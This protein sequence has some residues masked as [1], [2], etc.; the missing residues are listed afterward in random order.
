[1]IDLLHTLFYFIV[2]ISVL[3]SIHE[4]GHF[5][6]ARLTGVKVLRFSIGF[7]KVL[8]A[9][10]KNAGTTEYV[11]S[12]IPLGGYVKMVDERE[13]EVKDSDLPFAFNRQSILARTAIV[14][15]GP[16]FNLAL[17]V[18]LFWSVLVIGET[19]IKPILGAVEQGTLASAAGF[20]DGDEIIS[21]NGKTTPTW[22]EAM[23]V[24]ASLALDGERSIKIAIKSDDNRQV[25]K[26]LNIADKD[27]ENPETFYQRLGFKPWAPKLQPIIGK[28]LPDSAALAAGLQP[29]DLIISAGDTSVN[30]WMQW[31]AIVKSHPDMPIKLVIERDGVRLPIIITPKKTATGQKPEG[32]VGATVYISDKLL[33]SVS[34]EYALSP[35]EA[36]PVA[37]ETTYYYS[38]TSLKMMFKMLIGKASVENL[39]GPIGIAQYAGQSAAMGLTPFIKF[40]ALVSVSLG[41][42]N[43]LPIPVL[44]GGHLLFLAVEGIKGSPVSDKAQFF[45]QQIGLALLVSLMALSMFLDIERYF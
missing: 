22:T 5:W 31:V 34:A 23:T 43:L 35:L 13:G 25:T 24:L 20:A 12:A 26:T 9:Y 44:D 33:D 8:W 41:V 11:L 14:V 40:M 18:A 3:V 38:I 32:K 7:G 21:V 45:F 30:D 16:V 17:A 6:V 4:F 28:V 39:S 27:A 42:L 2:T 19:G 15:A 37:L 10:Q 36:I 29:G 1:M